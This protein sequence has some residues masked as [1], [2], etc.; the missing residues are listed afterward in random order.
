[1]PID[2]WSEI[3]IERLLQKFSDM[4]SNNFHNNCGVGER[5]G[6]EM[7][8]GARVKLGF[9]KN[10]HFQILFRWIVNRH[11]FNPERGEEVEEK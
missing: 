2:G 4:D 9:C 7:A 11:L 6:V 10:K 1:M 3:E 8:E 5:E